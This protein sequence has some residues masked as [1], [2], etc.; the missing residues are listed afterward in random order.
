MSGLH[1]LS[2]NLVIEN[3]RNV[4]LNG[5]KCIIIYCT[6][7]YHI[8]LGNSSNVTIKDLIITGCGLHVPLDV[9]VLIPP[10]IDQTLVYVMEL[11]YCSSVTVHMN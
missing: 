3:V 10:G 11:Y 9:M 7:E 4:S 1:Y 5:I 6:G 2:T 8:I